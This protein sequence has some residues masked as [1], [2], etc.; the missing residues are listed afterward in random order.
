M[1]VTHSILKHKAIDPYR[2]VALRGMVRRTRLDMIWETLDD[3]NSSHKA[4]WISQFQSW[5]VMATVIFGTLQA[6]EPPVLNPVTVAV[7]ETCFDSVFLG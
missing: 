4:W 7:V 1:L 2:S 3:P 6:T 5:L